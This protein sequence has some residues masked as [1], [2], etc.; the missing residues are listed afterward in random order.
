MSRP[1]PVEDGFF[2]KPISHSHAARHSCSNASVSVNKAPAKEMIRPVRA[3]VR[4]SFSLYLGFCGTNILELKLL[5]LVLGD[6]VSTKI[7]D[8]CSSNIGKPRKN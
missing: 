6:L 4:K 3:T 8:M 2:Y 7:S 5:E 1:S